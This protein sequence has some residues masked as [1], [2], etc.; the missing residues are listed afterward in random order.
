MSFLSS[1]A[2]PAA[3]EVGKSI[4]K[5]DAP[6]PDFHKAASESRSVASAIYGAASRVPMEGIDA[7]GKTYSAHN[8]PGLEEAIRGLGGQEEFEAMLRSIHSSLNRQGSVSSAT[9]PYGKGKI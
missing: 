7:P 2:I 9:V 1:I 6:A 5:D 4:F 8:F 3:L